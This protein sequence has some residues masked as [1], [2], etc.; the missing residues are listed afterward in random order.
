MGSHGRVLIIRMT[1]L[2]WTLGKLIW[3]G[4]K[5]WIWEEDLRPGDGLGGYCKHLNERQQWLNW[6]KARDGKKK[7]DYKYVLNRIW[8]WWIGRVNKSRSQQ[9]PQRRV[10]M[11][12]PATVAGKWHRFGNRGWYVWGKVWCASGVPK[13]RCLAGSWK[14]QWS[15]NGAVIA[16]GIFETTSSEPFQQEWIKIFRLKAL[17]RWCPSKYNANF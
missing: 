9:I 6:S 16:Q 3:Q 13:Q 2:H 5:R 8:D 1:W 7:I 11:G 17:T 12:A 14:K 15:F 4:F 10:I